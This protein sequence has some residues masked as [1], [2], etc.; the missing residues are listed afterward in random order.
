M[1]VAHYVKPAPWFLVV[2]VVFVTLPISIPSW[3]AIERGPGLRLGSRECLHGHFFT[4]THIGRPSN[5]RDRIIAL[6]FPNVFRLLGK[7]RQIKASVKAL[8]ITATHLNKKS[9][10][11]NSNKN[12]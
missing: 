7:G 6:Q 5:D 10:K 4:R 8:S 3:S 1:S 12:L 9:D 11:Q 2:N